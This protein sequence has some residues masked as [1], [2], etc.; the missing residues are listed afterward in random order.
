MSIFIKNIDEIYTV[1]KKHNVILDGY[2]FI[3]DDII[4]KIGKMGDQDQ[5]KEKEADEIIDATGKIAIPGLINTHTHSA[6][7]II[8]GYA[9]DLPLKTWLEEKI[10]P[11]ESRLRSD[12]FYWGAKLAILEMLKS[13]TTTF[14]DMYFEMD[15]TAQAVEETGI[16]AVLSEGLIEENDGKTGLENSVQFAENWNN[17]AEGRI[18]TMLAPH[19]PY[20]CSEDYLKKIIS[21]SE[22]T[23]LPLHTHLAETQ[24]EVDIIQNKYQ[25]TPVEYLE[26]TG[27]F[28]RSVTAAHCIYLDENDFDILARRDVR[29]AHNP[30]SN[31]KLGSGIAD[32]SK[33]IEK[34]IIVSLGTDGAS[35]NNNLDL[36]EEAKIGSYLQKVDKLNPALLGT[37]ELLEM[38]TVNGAKAAGIEKLGR[39]KENFLA[40]IVLVDT[41]KNSRFYP[42][43]NNLSNLLYSAG[44]ETVD[45]VIINGE[46]VVENRKFRYLKEKKI[47]NE[48][49]RRAKELI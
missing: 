29:V 30:L 47:F 40:D 21:Y 41:G 20:T 6:M 18:T 12:D 8:R 26:E 15:R 45:T 37:E 14:L 23:D 3:K 4:E 22:K 32:I 44:S 24:N 5:I 16:R 17:E 25:K 46:I 11:F 33:M 38:L 36:F 35:S 48:V 13:G 1:D 7:T 42:H 43:H 49:E 31:M 34:N 2:I 27:F 39:L 19:S 28:S 10:W 9:D